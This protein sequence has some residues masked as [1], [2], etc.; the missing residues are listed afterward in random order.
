V[1]L[2]VST[3]RLEAWLDG[4]QIVNVDTSGKMISTRS[5]VDLNKPFG[6]SSYQSTAGLRNIRIHGVDG[7]E[8]PK[9]DF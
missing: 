8:S 7:A 9:Q 2:R 1:R 3:N 4:E 5:E 6:F